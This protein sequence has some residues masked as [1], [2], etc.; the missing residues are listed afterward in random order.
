MPQNTVRSRWRGR[1]IATTLLLVWTLLAGRL[2]QLHWSSGDQFERLATRQHVFQETVPARPGE[3]VDRHGLVFASSVTVK[4]LYIAPNRIRKGWQVAQQLG[5]ALQLDPDR[6]FERSAAHPDR[7]F[8]WVKRRLTD[9]EVEQVRR[10]SLPAGAW[11]FR[12]EFRRVYPQGATAAQVIGLRD[13]D[14]IG[15]GGIEQSL[16]ARLR[17]TDGKRELMHDARGRVIEVRESA[18]QPVRHGEAIALTLDAVIQVHAERAL[19]Q[20]MQQWKPKSA[21]AVVLDP[22]NGDVLAMASRPTFD[23][24]QPQR[25]PADAWKN[26]AIADIYEPGSTFKPFVVARALERGCIARDEVFDC[27]N[28]EYRMGRRVLHDHHR[29]GRLSVADIL[30]KSSNIGM[31]KIGQRLSNRGLYEAALAFGFGNP[32]GIELP[33]ELPGMIRPLKRWN[34]Y[35]TGSVP[36]GQEIAATP[37][38]MIAAYAAL[39]NGGRLIAPHLIAVGVDPLDTDALGHSQRSIDVGGAIVSQAVSP[40]I[41]DWIRREALTA[42]VSRGTGKKAMIR[43]YD[44]FGKTGTAQKPDPV[45]GEYSR[46][47]HVS[48]FVCG[49]PADDPRVLVLISVDEPTVALNGEHFGGSVA[50][51]AAG[52]LLRLS[53]L[54]LQVPPVNPSHQT[55]LLPDEFG[56]ELLE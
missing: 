19:D 8:L 7:Q 13:I 2:A 51:P 11:G 24:N 10:L 53:L 5:Q 39:A 44:V 16:H 18:V 20:V 50:A 33:G 26:R 54:R 45:T 27:E 21:C 9:A 56:D 15:R 43:G 47:L 6:L 17:G 49:A 55:A 48:S 42:V 4:S 52:E 14:G 28:G 1:G 41:A 34:S 35:S 46:Q 23:P 30:V 37:L 22:R 36:I 31:A 40:E 25:V 29:Y 12:D 32:T 38:Q 3:I